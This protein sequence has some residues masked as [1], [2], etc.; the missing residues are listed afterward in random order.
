[1]FFSFFSE[2]SDIWHGLYDNCPPSALE[3]IDSVADFCN[4]Y[5]P[6]TQQMMLTDTRDAE[7]EAICAR[8][9]FDIE[10]NDV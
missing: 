1:M 9:N 3:F 2:L 10:D 8:F 4:A 6:G 5:S 7:H